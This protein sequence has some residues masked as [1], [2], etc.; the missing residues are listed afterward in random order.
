MA[1]WRPSRSRSKREGLKVLAP[2]TFFSPQT[3]RVQPSD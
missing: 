2:H 1:Q 3:D